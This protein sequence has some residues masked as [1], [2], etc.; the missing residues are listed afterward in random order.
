MYSVHGRVIVDN[1]YKFQHD[2]T[3]QKIVG[4]FSCVELRFRQLE[5]TRRFVLIRGQMVPTV[6]QL[7]QTTRPLALIGGPVTAR[8]SQVQTRSKPCLTS[9]LKKIAK[10]WKIVDFPPPVS[11]WVPVPDVDRSA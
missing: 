2:I 9:V 8:N 11:Q 6:G 10:N 7:E 3:L 5:R 1:L 4:R